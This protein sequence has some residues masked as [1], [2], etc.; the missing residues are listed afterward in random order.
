MEHYCPNFWLKILKFSGMSL[1]FSIGIQPFAGARVSRVSYTGFTP[2]FGMPPQ[3][4]SKNSLKDTIQLQEVTVS[5]GYQSI[6]KERATG[7]F[8]FI[9]SALFN[10]SVSTDVLSRLKGVT[11]SLLFD[12]R[13]GTPRLSI[14]GRGTIFANAA[15]LIVVDNFPYEGDLSTLNPNDVAS[16]SILRDAAAASIW[17]VRAGNGVIVI[18]TKQGRLNQPM[19]V[20]A[21]ANTTLGEKPDLFYQQKISPADLVDVHEMLYKAGY[22]KS[23]LKNMTTFPLVPPVAS[24]LN[25]ATLSESQQQAALDALRGNDLRRDLSRYFY[26]QQV[27]QQYALQL[28][29][30][31][32]THTYYLA[33]GYDH[34]RENKV[35]NTLNRF[36]LSTQH[37]FLLFKKL[38]AQTAL[39]LTQQH[40]EINNTLNQFLQPSNG[41]AAYPYLALKDSDGH[42]LAQPRDFS[43]T[44]ISQAEN[45]GLLNWEYYPLQELKGNDQQANNYTVRINS[46]LTY[47]LLPGLNAS[48]RYQYEQQ[49]G[50]EEQLYSQTSY[51]T[52][53]L[54]NRYTVI[55]A[56][57]NKNNL[58]LGAIFDNSQSWMRA[59]NL[60]PQL[61]YD[62][63]NDQDA[64]NLLAGFEA[65]ELKTETRQA[66]LYGYEPANGTAIPVNMDSLYRQYPGSGTQ[67]IS[68]LKDQNPGGTIERYRSWFFNGAYTYLQRYVVSGSARIDQ[69]NLF[70][71]QANQRTIPLWS[72]GIKWRIDQESWYKVKNLPELAFRATYGYNG[73]FD[74]TATAFIT[75]T[76]NTNEYSLREARLSGLPNPELRGERN[77]VLNL[78]MDF[79]LV[80]GSLSGS[81]DYYHRKGKDLIGEAPIDASTGRTTFRGNVA[82]MSG[83]GWDVT[84]N[85]RLM[86]GAF[87]WNSQAFASFTQDEVTHYETKTTN[88]FND[89]SIGGQNLF[90]NPIEGKPLFSVYSYRW[91][92]LDP[93]TGAPRGYLEG[94]PS[95]DYTAIS[96]AQDLRYH[97]RALPAWIGS[98]RNDLD[99]RQWSLSVN[100]SYKLG[101]YFRRPSST[102]GS[103]LS[104][105]SAGHADFAKRWQK[106]GDEAFTQVPAWIYPVNYGAD[107]FYTYSE[108]LVEKGDHIRLQ[109]VRLSY[110]LKKWQLFVYANNLGILWRANKHGIDPDYNALVNLGTVALPTPRSYAVGLTTSF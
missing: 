88:Y 61:T 76:Y 7:S 1:V 107:N 90:L 49:N 99:Y 73:N 13:S 98:W 39:F 106:P 62:F 26:Q 87:S 12:E 35:G 45:K 86:L 24:I 48:F 54:I 32:Q 77:A 71:V 28:K 4:T 101:F 43:P 44:F 75:A 37:S 38:Q 70:G 78:G 41:T 100:I 56:S 109:D 105:G 5:T 95:T 94:Q 110:H 79:S 104:Q 10:R 65:R 68:A 27:N 97:G 40:R 58:P 53:N 42:E 21:Q 92:G 18:T 89:P 46:A 47:P 2:I 66:R 60:R 83:H 9:D 80:K 52:R 74:Q 57:G 6:P 103:L 50:R 55:S 16:V 81:L 33:A 64:V 102:N 72:A 3:D 15:P 67:K 30:G 96:N 11:P 25:D 22:Y 59:Y 91:A 93:Q 36:N 51:Y 23:S 14:R 8:V 19:Q 17:G 31:G 34:V 63:T 69:T 85:G 84:L 29:G 108:I 82:A 20:T